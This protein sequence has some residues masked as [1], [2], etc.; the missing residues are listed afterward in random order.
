MYIVFGFC[1]DFDKAISLLI[2]SVFTGIGQNSCGINS[3]KN[4]C[5]IFFCRF[6]TIR[7][8]LISKFNFLSNLSLASFV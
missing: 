7:N 3:Q 4:C 2:H 5:I 8:S 1:S 6:W